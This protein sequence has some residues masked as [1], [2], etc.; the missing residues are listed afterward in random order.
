[1]SQGFTQV[2]G[3]DKVATLADI[4]TALA[5]RRTMDQM[6]Q[7]Y[8]LVAI[9]TVGQGFDMEDPQAP[10]IGYGFEIDDAGTYRLVGMSGPA[11]FVLRQYVGKRLDQ[12]P[13]VVWK[14]HDETYADLEDGHFFY[15]LYMD[16]SP[17]LLLADTVVGMGFEP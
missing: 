4:R 2:P 5:E 12:I 15:G 1:M 3:T 11:S 14:E 7:D 6:R 13:I 9:K 16:D 10:G 8:G 17:G